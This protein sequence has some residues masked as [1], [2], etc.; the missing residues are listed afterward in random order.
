VTTPGLKVPGA[1][2]GPYPKSAVQQDIQY[3]K[4]TAI[5]ALQSAKEYVSTSVEDVKRLIENSG[6]TVG[7]YLPQSVTA[8]LPHNSTTDNP[9][10]CEP[11][12]QDVRSASLSEGGTHPASQNEHPES[13]GGASIPPGLESGVAIPTD[14]R[15]SSQGNNLNSETLHSETAIANPPED[16][17]QQNP[18]LNH[19]P[20]FMTENDL[21]G[22]KEGVGEERK[23]VESSRDTPLATGSASAAPLPTVSD[24]N[25][26]AS[27]TYASHPTIP[28][29]TA[30]SYPLASDGFKFGVPLSKGFQQQLDQD[31]S[32]ATENSID[33][34]RNLEHVRSDAG[35]AGHGAEAAATTT[36]STD[37]SSHAEHQTVRKKLGF[38]KKLKQEVK[39]I[40]GKLHLRRGK[41]VVGVV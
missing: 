24:E 6:D 8:Y 7:G 18:I 39:G 38:M 35:T 2:P 40:P 1:F 11:K 29:T 22:V 33:E 9:L 3:V 21:P 4:D 31:Q 28:N 26:T 23:P 15:V 25:T 14:E 37:E 32:L 13:S 16:R 5:V 34:R 10:A 20:P 12:S 41:D 36:S 19:A 27:S 17:R 30:R